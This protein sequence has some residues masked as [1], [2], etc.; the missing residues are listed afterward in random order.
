MSFSGR[1]TPTEHEVEERIFT[2][3]VAEIFPIKKIYI[4]GIVIF[5]VLVGWAMF[6]MGMVNWFFF[7]GGV[8]L[9]VV[10]MGYFMYFL[11]GV[12]SVTISSRGIKIS[13]WRKTLTYTWDQIK[14][15]AHTGQSITLLLTEDGGYWTSDLR[16]HVT[17]IDIGF[18]TDD[19]KK[20]EE[21][22]RNYE[23]LHRDVYKPSGPVGGP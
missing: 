5:A 9:F 17:I 3:S 13:K 16:D 2:T 10:F 11:I 20:L 14:Q 7:I 6:Y 1:D 23:M 8:F 19:W 22:I 21:S 18:S 12:K 15:P 4:V